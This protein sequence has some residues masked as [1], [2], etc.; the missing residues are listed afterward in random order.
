[1]GDIMS[2]LQ[3]KQFDNIYCANKFLA[4]TKYH[5]GIKDIIIDHGQIWI[6]HYA[7]DVTLQKT[8]YKN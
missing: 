5:M 1:M 7:K 3:I 2:I 8:N 4:D 6:I